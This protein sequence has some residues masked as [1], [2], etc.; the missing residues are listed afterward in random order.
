MNSLV[1]KP[2]EERIRER[3]VQIDQEEK[4]KAAARKEKLAKI[5]GVPVDQVDS[6]VNNMVKKTAAEQQKNA[7][8]NNSAN[9][10]NGD[11][12]KNTSA[13]IDTADTKK[14]AHADDDGWKFK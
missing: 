10:D 11:S 7:K 3:A 12:K 1:S 4:Q 5:L 9:I 13:N 14:N 6:M 8:Q 2:D